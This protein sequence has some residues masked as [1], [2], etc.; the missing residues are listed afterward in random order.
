MSLVELH[1]QVILRDRQCVAAVYDKSHVCKDKFGNE[2]L[3]NDLHKLTLEHVKDDRGR[4]IDGEMWCI[5]LCS[6]AN[7]QQHWSSANREQA[8]FY[9]AGVKAGR[10][11]W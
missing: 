5:A 6:E 10:N 9:L 2:H 4:R 11:R 7:V 1:R 8:I 3:A